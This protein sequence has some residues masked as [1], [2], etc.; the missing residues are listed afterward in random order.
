MLSA[1]CALFQRLNDDHGI[2]ASR[3]ELGRLTL[4]AGNDQ[5]AEALFR[6]ILSELAEGGAEPDTDHN[7]IEAVEGLAWIA[8]TRGDASHAARLLG[9]ADAHR[10]AHGLPFPSRLDRRKHEARL[11]EVRSE[12]GPAWTTTWESAASMSPRQV[13]DLALSG[14]P[15]D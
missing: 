1:A 14:T 11:R 5:R 15:E 7:W 13:I 10:D 4:A 9:A 12:A 8:R 2:G 3:A 6:D